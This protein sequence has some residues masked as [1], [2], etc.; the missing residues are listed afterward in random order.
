[1]II[2]SKLKDAAKL[3]ICPQSGKLVSFGL[4][5]KKCPLY[6]TCPGPKIP[7]SDLAQKLPHENQKDV[8]NIYIPER[9]HFPIERSDR[10]N[11]WQAITGIIRQNDSILDLG[12]GTGRFAKY[13]Q[14]NNFRGKYLGIEWAASRVA[15]AQHYVPGYIF[16]V[17]DIYTKQA[18]KFFTDFNII[19]LLEV[20]V[21]CFDETRSY[22]LVENI[23][24]NKRV[25][26]TEPI[27]PSS[28][29]KQPY[30]ELLD[31]DYMQRFDGIDITLFGARRK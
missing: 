8:Y 17:A 25:I 10:L 5:C 7:I 9:Q 2:F 6:D 29:R 14:I 3:L 23:P 31:I 24:L 12:C 26:F 13:L 30:L 21:Q 18:Y 4:D 27:Q 16:R 20:I 19:L 11:L 28:P 22:E 15:L 1:M